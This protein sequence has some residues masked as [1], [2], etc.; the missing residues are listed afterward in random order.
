MQ[1]AASFLERARVQLAVRTSSDKGRPVYLH[2][3]ACLARRIRN[4][5]IECS[6]QLALRVASERASLCS[7]T[8]I[9]FVEA[10]AGLDCWKP[11][12]HAR[13]V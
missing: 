1:A 4:K 2:C 10:A 11:R 9:K 12:T 13:Y 7:H 8:S 5:R 3:M 6:F